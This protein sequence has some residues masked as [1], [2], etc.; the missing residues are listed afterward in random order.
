MTP[1]RSAVRRDAICSVVAL[2]MPPVAACVSRDV[3]SCKVRAVT[4]S[5]QQSDVMLQLLLTDVAEVYVTSLPE[6]PCCVTK[7]DA[8]RTEIHVL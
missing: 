4:V 8:T 2:Y 1:R 6:M 3:T 7:S 5:Y